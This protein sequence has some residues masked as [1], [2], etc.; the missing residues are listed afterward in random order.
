MSSPT[1]F[2]NESGQDS[3]LAMGTDSV[4]ISSAELDVE[5]SDV[6]ELLSVCTSISGCTFA[7]DETTP[8]DLEWQA[9]RVLRINCCIMSL[10]VFLV[11][12]Y[13]V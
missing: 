10:P 4:E 5:S 9:I 6:A 2:G 12:A 1:G 8:S 3:S 11:S 13:T 7:D